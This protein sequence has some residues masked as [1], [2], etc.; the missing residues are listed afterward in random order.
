MALLG[1]QEHVFRIARWQPAAMVLDIKTYAIVF[2]MS[3]QQ[4]LSSR[5]C[6]FDDV[7]KQIA[8]SGLQ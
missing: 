4:D 2:S 3:G 1:A 6:E 8:D 5:C 7:T